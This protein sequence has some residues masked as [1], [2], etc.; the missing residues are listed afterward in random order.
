MPLFTF[1]AASQLG[2]I[3]ADEEGLAFCQKH[4]GELV[5]ATVS[6]PRSLPQNSLLWGVG[7]V[8]YA[9][10]SEGLSRRWARKEDMI[11]GLKLRLGIVDEIATW[12]A[13]GWKI[14][15]RPRSLA[16]MEAPEATGAVDRL[17]DGM[18]ALLHVSTEELLAAAQEKIGTSAR[19]P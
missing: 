15:A 4:A 18:A 19:R 5:Q 7:G 1:R 6:Q 13:S 11:D 14:V 12:D 9:T 17:L 10:M 16:R 8:C 3:P 2:L